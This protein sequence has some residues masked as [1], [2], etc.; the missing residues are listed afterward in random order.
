MA[1]YTNTDKT[2]VNPYHFVPLEDSCTRKIN[3]EEYLNQ[4][5]LKTGWIEC[6]LTTLTPVFIPNTTNND[7]FKERVPAENKIIKS[8]DFYSYADNNN[9]NECTKTAIIPG[10]SIRGA[11]RSAFETL[12]NSCMS[13]TDDNYVLYKRVTTPA[14]K[15]GRLVKRNNE[16][17]IVE[18]EKYMLKTQ[19]CSADSSPKFNIS[20]YKDKQE[21]YIKDGGK[22]KN[23]TY[24]PKTIAAINHAKTIDCKIKGYIHKGE[25]F[26]RRKHHE[27]VF[28]EKGNATS[29]S[30]RDVEN[31]LE[32]YRLFQNETVNLHK[33]KEE[34]EGYI[35]NIKDADH[36]QIDSLDGSLV[37]YAKHN[38]KFYLSPAAIGREVFH[39]RLKDL[40]GSYSPC[41]SY[42]SLC[43][44]CALFGFVGNSKSGMDG[45]S[46]NAIASR[47]RFS[48][49]KTEKAN[50]LAPVILPELAGPKIS[51][52]GLY[53]KKPEGTNVAM[54]NYDYAEY[55]ATNR[56]GI[57]VKKELS[58]YEPTIQGRKFYWHHD[59]YKMKTFDDENQ[60]RNFTNPIPYSERLVKIRP[61]DTGTVFK[62][63]IHFNR[64]TKD[65]LDRLAWTL[66]LGDKDELAHKIGMGKPVGLGSARIKVS[67]IITRELSIDNGVF[68]YAEHSEYTVDDKVK[69]G[70]SDEIKKA[71]YK[72][73]KFNNQL[74]NIHYPY[75]IDDNNKVI[76]E[77]YE[78]FV[79]NKQINGEG[80]GT[81][82]FIS[83]NLKPINSEDYTLNVIKKNTG[84]APRQQ[85]YIDNNRAT[86]N[87]QHGVTKKKEKSEAEK[88]IET[89]IKTKSK[90]VHKILNNLK[91]LNPSE[92]D[93]TKIGQML[94]KRSDSKN[95]SNPMVQNYLKI[96]QKM[97]G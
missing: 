7:F 21:V 87:K 76:P 36:S 4:A 54:W 73:T 15:C 27:S 56:Q 85:N 1:Y 41:S 93:I 18:C 11:I 42:D 72:I 35:S 88:L 32:N 75:C 53:M 63:K 9:T 14:R 29:V 33:K 71:F 68:N 30:Q 17:E 81:N 12:T 78:W 37:Y 8:Y 79:G 51:S 90:N 38:G 74:K 86:P 83:N 16:W 94:N 97:K 58:N 64:L 25:P 70:C 24:M 69:L 95:K 20:N 48:D 52:T 13:T 23:K 50:F 31:L 65:E 46:K 89:I 39:N 55:N 45:R 22:Y 66:S 44:A 43:P 34:H 59:N 80:T 49:A 3:Y 82:N 6:E 40:I 84:N 5:D 26:G 92:E 2:F 62:F 47:V 57:I 19:N 91:A 61:V 60:T 10:S 67:K 77:N 28:V 96:Y